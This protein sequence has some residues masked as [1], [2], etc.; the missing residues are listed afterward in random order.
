MAVCVAATLPITA[1]AM[2][3]GSHSHDDHAMS[4][5][6]VTEAYARAATPNARAGAAFMLITNATETDD[7]LIAFTTEAARRSEIH[8]HVMTDDGVMQMRE[9]EGGIAIAAGETATLQR[10]GDHLMLMGLT[11]PFEQ[12]AAIEV[13]LTFETAGEVTVPVT[14]DNERAPREGAGHGGQGGHGGDHGEDHGDHGD[15]HGG[16]GGHSNLESDG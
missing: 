6:T 2:D 10:G 9:I 1:F 15:D 16:H 4:G 14:I 3:D 11:V 8:E 13:T 7:R 5:I 12:G